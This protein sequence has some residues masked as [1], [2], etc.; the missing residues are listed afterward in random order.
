MDTLSMFFFVVATA[1][2]CIV[3]MQL[4]SI[5]LNYDSIL[6][7]NDTYSSLENTRSLGGLFIDKRVFD[8]NDA[9]ADETHKWRCMRL[10]GEYMSMSIF[11]I[12]AFS[13]GRIRTF[14]TYSDCLEFTFA[15]ASGSRIVNPCTDEDMK[16][17]ELCEY[18][19]SIL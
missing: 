2:A 10:R 13:D 8:P 7:F 9:I 16:N 6:E 18:L 11:G 17:P 14:N 12:Y 5:Y 1:A 19:K 15:G 4:Y 3:V